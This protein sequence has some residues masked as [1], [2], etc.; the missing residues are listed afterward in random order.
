MIVT[1]SAALLGAGVATADLATPSLELAPC[2]IEDPGGARSAAARCGHLSVAEN[3][4][5]P[6]GRRIELYVA[7]VPALHVH[8]QADALTVIAGGPGAAAT[9]F[10]VDYAAAFERVHRERDILLVDQRGTGASHPL[11]CPDSTSEDANPDAVRA[12]A[13]RCVEALDAD[14][15]YYTTSIAVRDLD[16]VRAALGY[17]QLDLYGVSYGTRV[18]LHYL[19]RYPQRTRAVILDGVLPA[20][21]ALGPGIA[22]DAQHALD[23]MFERCAADGACNE[24]FPDVRERFAELRTRLGETPLTL[25]L[26]DPQSAEPV[27]THFGPNELDA[28]VRL[29]SYASDTVA[30]LPLLLDR[31]AVG[32]VAPL[33]A[34]SLMVGRDLGETLSEGMHNAV[35][36]T[37]DVPFFELDDSM[38]AALADTYLST[39]QVDG[40]IAIC[41]VWPRGVLDPD[42]KAPVVSDRPVLLLSGE[43]DPVTPPRNAEHALA[44]LSHGF[45]LVAVG[46]GHGVAALGCVPQLIGDFIT[47]ASADGLDASCMKRLGPAPFFTSFNGPEP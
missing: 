18:A 14:P 25:T 44:T 29:L 21:L 7:V 47:A 43:S 10:Y 4:D 12:A 46:Q 33:A 40:L 2:R 8:A 30:L 9:A 27:E 11:Q 34:Q 20:D 24:H 13:Q 17:A 26:A 19:R 39:T 42:F 16:A 28:A 3:P 32:E 45:S 15:R 37:E 6:D 1:L 41:D 31:A 5:A 22:L 23:R 35:V 38:R 36:C